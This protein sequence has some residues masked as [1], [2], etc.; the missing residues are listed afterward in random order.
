MDMTRYLLCN[1]LGSPQIQNSEW[2]VIGRS[3]QSEVKSHHNGAETVVAP[4][5]R[6]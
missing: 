5:G 2:F 1:L 4:L 3:I 6:N